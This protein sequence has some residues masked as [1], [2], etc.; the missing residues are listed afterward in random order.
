MRR[1]VLLDEL[2]R[3]ERDVVE[4]ERQLAEQEARVVALKRENGGVLKAQAELERMRDDHRRRG[5]D[6]QRLLAL[7]HP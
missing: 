2:S 5:Q 4:G 3:V 7:L 1:D 6:R